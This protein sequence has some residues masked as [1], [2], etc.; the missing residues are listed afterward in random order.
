MAVTLSSADYAA[1]C[2]I[3]AG[4]VCQLLQ[5]RMPAGLGTSLFVGATTVGVGITAAGHAWSF[6]RNELLWL[7]VTAGLCLLWAFFGWLA[8]RT[9]R[10]TGESQPTAAAKRREDSISSSATFLAW[11]LVT[12]IAVG[13]LVFYLLVFHTWH[14]VVEPES[15]GEGLL[16]HGGL[17]DLGAL[18]GAVL[19]WRGVVTRPTQP[20]VMLTLAAFTIWWTSLALPVASSGPDAPELRPMWWDWTFHLQFGLAVLLAAAAVIQDLRYR[21]RRR[22][23]LRAEAVHLAQ[24]ME[25]YSRW[26]AYIQVESTIAAAVLILG[27]YQLVRSGPPSVALGLAGLAACIMAGTTCMFTTYRRWSGNTAGLGIALKV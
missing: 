11:A 4:M 5:R 26:P 2:L 9:E 1:A 23:P 25:P 21:A 22:I 10:A 6:A 16:W 13:V 19:L 15:I 3:V 18:F 20:V 7:R 27:V 17:W 8:A 14:R 12:G 24:L